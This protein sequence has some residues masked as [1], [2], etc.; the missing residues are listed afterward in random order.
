[1]FD[2]LIDRQNRDVSR[3][4]ESSVADE[5]LKASQHA[6]GTVRAAID[7]IDVI[8]T[9]QVEAFFGDRLALMPEQDFGF[10]SE[11]LFDIRAQLL[12]RHDVL[13][14]IHAHSITGYL[15]SSTTALA[16]AAEVI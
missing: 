11:D 7:A 12:D 15:K 5:R 3:S 14:E 13:S 2:A 9:R 4:C 16:T 10:L 8:R 1:M 6:R